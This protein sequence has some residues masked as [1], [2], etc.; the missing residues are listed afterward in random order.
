MYCHMNE[1]T[2][3]PRRILRDKTCALYL[4]HN[5]ERSHSDFC[6]SL[7][8]KCMDTNVFRFDSMLKS[9]T[10]HENYFLIKIC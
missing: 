7:L 3:S 2:T 1:S 10:V 5:K 4:T 8:N 9:N 6:A